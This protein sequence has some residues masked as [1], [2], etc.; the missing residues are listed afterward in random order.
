M[1]TQLFEYYQRLSIH[2]S[3]IL[4]PVQYI[5]TEDIYCSKHTEHVN[6]Y[7]Y[8]CTSVC[9]SHGYYS[10]VSPG[11]LRQCGSLSLSVVS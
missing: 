8:R 11:L 7:I 9:S 3:D 4:S 10:V 1:C 2:G 5:T 6:V